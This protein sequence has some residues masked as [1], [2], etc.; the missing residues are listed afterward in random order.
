MALKDYEV[1]TTCPYGHECERVDEAE[2]KIFRCSHYVALRGKNPQGEDTLDEWGCSLGD[3]LPILLVE[4]AQT[5]RGQTHAIEMFRNEVVKQNGQMI[6]ATKN[7]L[8]T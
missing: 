5:N 1:V 6:E 8:L 3:W 4:N 2:K 7:T